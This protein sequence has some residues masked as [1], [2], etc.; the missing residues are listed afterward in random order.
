MTFKTVFLLALASGRRR[1]ELHALQA[2]IQRTENWEEITIFTDA[3]FISKTQLRVK[4]GEALKP[5]T[6]KAL[7]KVVGPEL[8]EDRS[9]CVVRAVKYYLKRTKEFRKNR[10]PLFISY[11]KG[12]EGE[13]C[14]NTISGWIKKAVKLAYQSSTTEVQQISGVRA[15]DVRSLA[16]SWALLRNVSIDEVLE[17]CSWKAHNTFTQYYLKDLTRIQ[18]KMLKLGPVVAALHTV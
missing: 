1:G 8:Q 5:M 9:L 17:A 2:N 10:T 3:K 12:Y 13:I 14:K 18:D 15:H 6:L 4:G 7:T 11:K 16:S